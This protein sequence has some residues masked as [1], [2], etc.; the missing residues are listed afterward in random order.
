VESIES[1]H[2]KLEDG[3]T[4][5]ADI[6]FVATGVTPSSLFSESGLPTGED[7]GLLVNDCLQCVDYPEIFGGGDCIKVQGRDL[8]R[9]GVY[10]VRQ[11][12]VLLHN[13]SAALEAKP[14]QRFNPGSP[15]FL[16]IVNLGDS[17]ALLR[18][19]KWIWNGSMAFKLKD[20]IDRRFM[21]KFQLSGELE[22][23]L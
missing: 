10:A 2:I 11:N 14:L 5:D 9:A 21:R 13:L 20:F 6:I 16:L 19:G 4:S 1:S 18:K 7:G 8:A 3:S 22:E 17:T 12:P 15:D 23:E